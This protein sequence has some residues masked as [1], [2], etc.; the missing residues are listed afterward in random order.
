MSKVKKT[1]YRIERSGFG[2]KLRFALVSDLHGEDPQD[3]I[4]IIKEE[5]PDYI[6][7][8]GDI[9]ER[10][11]GSRESIN[12]N[13]FRLFEAIGTLAPTFFSVGNH[14]NGGVRSWN[15]GW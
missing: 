8:P 11:D 2:K 12:E 9:F 10:L 13:G 6:L 4:Q 1:F 15:P 14:E 7:C 3:V 5:R